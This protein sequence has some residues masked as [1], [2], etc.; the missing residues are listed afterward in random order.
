MDEIHEPF[1]KRLSLLVNAHYEEI[2][3]MWTT[4]FY[5]FLNDREVVSFF[6]SITV[7]NI[8]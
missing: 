2:L 3:I 8:L 7:S 5:L 6:N 1:D 4:T